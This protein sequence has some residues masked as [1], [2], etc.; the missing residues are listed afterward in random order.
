MLKQCFWERFW[1]ILK[2]SKFFH[3]LNFSEFRPPKV[4]WAKFSAQKN[5]LE[6]CW[7]HVWT[8]LGTYL[9]ISK[10]WK[11]FKFFE[12]FPSFDPPGCSGQ[13]KF[14]ASLDTFGNGFRDFGTLKFF[15][16]L[17]IFFSLQGA[18]GR[19]FCVEKISQ[20][21]LKQCFLG[22]FLDNFENFEV[23][24][25]LKIFSKPQPYRTQY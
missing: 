22:T 11:L 7:K 3:F 12:V 18:L 20:N 9:R 15:P 4:P 13:E 8:L 16:F 5:Y 17:W 25:F 2:V 23:F 21:I 10:K 24:H 19:A 6:A 14:G 1:T